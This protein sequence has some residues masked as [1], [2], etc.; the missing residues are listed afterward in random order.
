MRIPNILISILGQ[1][2]EIASRND[3]PK[4]RLCPRL[5]GLVLI[6]DLQVLGDE[7]RGCLH[8]LD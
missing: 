5:S 4:N 1:Q 7:A 8:D 2:C 6:L 3:L